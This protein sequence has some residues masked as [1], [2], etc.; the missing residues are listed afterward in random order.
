MAVCGSCDTKNS[1]LEETLSRLQKELREKDRLLEGFITIAAA[2]SKHISLTPPSLAPQLVS[3]SAATLP[4]MASVHSPNGPAEGP[5]AGGSAWHSV[6]LADRH[7]ASPAAGQDSQGL[8]P[9]EDLDAGVEVGHLAHPTHRSTPKP[10]AQPAWLEVVQ[11]GRRSTAAGGA[12]TP[13][14]LSLSNRFS[15]PVRAAEPASAPAP[16]LLTDWVPVEAAPGSTASAQRATGEAGRPASTGILRRRLLK[17]AVSR[18]SGGLPRTSNTISPP[19]PPAPAHQQQPSS[20]QVVRPRSGG[21]SMRTSSP[22]PLLPPTTLIIGD[23]ITRYIRFFN[24]I[25]HCCPGATVPVILDKLLHLLPSLPS[26]VTKI[27]VHVGT[28]DTSHRQSEVTRE[29]LTCFLTF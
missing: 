10:E 5:A 1:R 13:P 2:Q 20:A 8:G 27:V 4:W 6:E 23:S 24:A 14:R 9:P 26:S 7:S 25:T 3:A 11:R 16:L 17:E 21:S 22:R 15:A 29:I 19:G 12:P 28:N 18:R